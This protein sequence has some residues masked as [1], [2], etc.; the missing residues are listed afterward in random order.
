MEL[1]TLAS[2]AAL[3]AVWSIEV[4]GDIEDEGIDTG[5]GSGSSGN[6][7]G[8]RFSLPEIRSTGATKR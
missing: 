8:G 5:S 3:T 2:G 7:C 4:K 1:R 6:A